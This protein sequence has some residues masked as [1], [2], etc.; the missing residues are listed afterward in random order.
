[1]TQ[2]IN[3]SET[4]LERAAAILR[5]KSTGLSLD[6]LKAFSIPQLTDCCDRMDTALS[7]I[8]VADTSAELFPPAHEASENRKRCPGQRADKPYV[9][10]E[11]RA[12]CN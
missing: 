3:L 11:I 10:F 5:M 7:G 1:M 12:D 2:T 9:H 8:H 6:W 4:L